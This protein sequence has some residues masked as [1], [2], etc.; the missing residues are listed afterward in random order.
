MSKFEDDLVRGCLPTGEP[1]E[2]LYGM[3]WW[4]EIPEE[5]PAPFDLRVEWMNEDELPE[6]ISDEVFSAMYACSK[7]DFVRFYPFVTIDGDKCFLI[8]SPEVQE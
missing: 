5:E 1:L 8:K 3:G 6:G 4:T 7:V 2:C